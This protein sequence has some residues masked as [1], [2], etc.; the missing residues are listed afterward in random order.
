MT[1]SL[2]VVVVEDHEALREMTVGVLASAGWH[3]RGFESAEALYEGIGL[4]T[5]DIALL[6]LN[7]P[8]EDGLTLARR[9][10][11]HQPNIGIVMLT[12]REGIEQRVSGYE[13]G[14]D[15]YLPK[16]AAGAELIAAI[17]ALA[18]RLGPSSR[19]PAFV[20]DLAAGRL[21]GPAGSVSLLEP[22]ALLLRAFALA[23]EGKLETWQVYEILGEE[24]ASRGAIA[25]RI[26]RLRKK[27]AEAG[28]PEEALRAVRNQGYR[29]FIGLAVI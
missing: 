27:L 18:R 24:N 23:P 10:R 6:D 20:L 11:E 3:V 26:T 22:E 19:L 16:P 4:K 13:H 21:R 9:L 1:R 12:V 7:L 25:I 5:I 29:L 14:A 17:A 15:L 2:N 28:A 8:G